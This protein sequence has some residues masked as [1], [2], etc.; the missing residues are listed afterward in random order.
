MEI[1]GPMGQSR[2]YEWS[3]PSVRED[4]KLQEVAIFRLTNLLGEHQKIDEF[5]LFI[6]STIT[7]FPSP[8]KT[9]A[10]FSSNSFL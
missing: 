7:I 6:P 8:N 3:V 9:P 2:S 10:F 1:N 4:S 5:I